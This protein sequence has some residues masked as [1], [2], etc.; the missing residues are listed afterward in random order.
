MKDVFYR[1][2]ALNS[3]GMKFGT[4]ATRTLLDA[5]GSPDRGLKIVH[6]AGTNGKGSVAEYVT[7]ILISSG[8][9]T[10]TFTSPA[11]YDYFE[12]FRI[13]GTPIAEDRLSGYFERAYAAANG[14]A[15]AFEV[16]TA[17]ALLAFK[18][19]G[20]E[21]AVIECGLGGRDDA[22]NAI[23]N[24]ELALI[25]SIGLEHTAYLGGSLQEIAAHKAGI[26]KNCPA[27]ASNLQPPEAR[28]FLKNYGVRFADRNLQIIGND[29]IIY[30]NERYTLAMCGLAQP[31]NAA[32][33]IEAA[34]ALKIPETAI[35]KGIETARI[36]G[37]IE[38]IECLGNVY[39]L[40]GAHNPPAMQILAEYLK[41]TYKNERLTIIFG[42]LSDKD[43]VGNAKALSELNAEIICVKPDSPR[44]MQ[45]EKIYRTFA[46][47]FSRVS[48]AESVTDALKPASGTVVVCGS[49]TLL[50]EAKEWIEKRS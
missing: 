32:L 38:R 35:K 34:R 5:L 15:T 49:F 31:Y 8:K 12:Q 30:A 6:I 3:V 23:S 24:K 19:E 16:M 44:A 29:R 1:I 11:V 37:R 47:Q 4:N 17:G 10:G 2:D 14:R 9:K 41:K 20:C 42:C 22:T 21:Y 43:V 50:K 26:I 45:F 18:E 7:Q 27:I 36:I 28:E 33:A 46:A 13:D 39:I 48:A 40:D 25:T